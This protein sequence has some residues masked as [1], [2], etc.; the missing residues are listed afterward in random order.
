MI[1]KKAVIIMV[2]GYV[3]YFTCSGEKKE[4]HY[5]SGFVELCNSFSP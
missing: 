3:Q 4:K 2:V 5:L 1:G